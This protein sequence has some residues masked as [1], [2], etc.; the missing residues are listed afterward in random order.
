MTKSRQGGLTSPKNKC[1]LVLNGYSTT[2]LLLC[3]GFV[4]D[5]VNTANT[6]SPTP[7]RQ[8]QPKANFLL[9]S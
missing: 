6:D 5:I 9:F 4:R 1:F 3:Q 8:F 7:T 2:D